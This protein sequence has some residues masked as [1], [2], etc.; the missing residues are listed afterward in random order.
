MKDIKNRLLKLAKQ[1]DSSFRL[2]DLDSPSF[3]EFD[4]YKWS[5]YVSDELHEVWDALDMESKLV[6]YISAVGLWK[7]AIEAMPFP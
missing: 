6:A 3:D 5:Y 7:R 1:A 4:Q 2:S